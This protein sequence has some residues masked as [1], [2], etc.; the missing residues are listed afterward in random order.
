T[1]VMDVEWERISEESERNPEIEP[2]SEVLTENLAYVIY[3]SGST[4]EPKGVAVHQRALIARTVALL[5]SYD[6]TSAD[7]LLQFVSPS[8]DAFGEE[9]FTSLS[10]GASL[11]IDRRVVNYSAHDL[12]NLVERSAIT[13]LHIPP[14]YWHHLVDELSSSQ[15]QVSSQL[16]L[17]ITG[18]ESPSAETLQKWVL[19]TGNQSRF[20]NAYGPTEATI[21]STVYELQMG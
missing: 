9:V 15:R 7:R 10:C 12:F 16:R 21:T 8:F 14:A 5:E 11:V 13:V 4:G 18:G 20:V 19:L 1:V 6:L 2:E 3:T 17:F